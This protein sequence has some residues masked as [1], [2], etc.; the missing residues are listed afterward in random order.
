[1]SNL[2]AIVY[3]GG[4]KLVFTDVLLG[5]R[6]NKQWYKMGPDTKLWE[7]GVMLLGCLVDKLRA[8]SR[9][10]I[11]LTPKRMDGIP[12]PFY[13]QNIL[14]NFSMALGFAATDSLNKLFGILALAEETYIPGEIPSSLFPDY[15]KS[16]T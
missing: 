5:Y 12:P 15:N 3:S 4:P 7:R 8:E 1:M 2:N 9:Y 10:V 11:H 13:R 6:C 14:D 16:A